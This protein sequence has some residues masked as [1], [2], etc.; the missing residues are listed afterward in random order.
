MA[1][2]DNELSEMMHALMEI[3]RGAGRIKDLMRKKGWDEADSPDDINPEDEFE[4]DL[5][6]WADATAYPGHEMMSCQDISARIF[7]ELN[8]R[9][10]RDRIV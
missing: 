10:N 6:V 5:F 1:F 8:A 2:T 7:R 3:H 9:K 4:R